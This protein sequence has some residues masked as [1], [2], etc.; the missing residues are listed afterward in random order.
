MLQHSFSAV[1]MV[2]GGH[3][4]TFDLSE[5]IFFSILSQKTITVQNSI[6]GGAQEHLCR[7]SHVP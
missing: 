1:K 4:D 7:A 5:G 3:L 2:A 6:S